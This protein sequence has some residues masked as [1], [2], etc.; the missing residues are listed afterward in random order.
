MNTKRSPSPHDGYAAAGLDEPILTLRAAD[1]AAPVVIRQWA[2]QQRALIL[3]GKV[4]PET[5]DQ[6]ADAIRTAE[7]MEAW[8]RQ[9]RGRG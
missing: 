7:A 4:P 5:E 2:Y 6:V 8:R 1:P 9:H 3:A